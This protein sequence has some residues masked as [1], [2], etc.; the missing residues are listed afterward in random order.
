M[1]LPVAVQR[2]CY[3]GAYRIL[4]VTWF[5]TRPR[6]RG[7]KCLLTQDDRILLVRHTYGRRSWDL[8]GGGVKR[9]EPPIGA[10]RR[11]MREEL[12]IQAADW[13]AAG[14]LHGRQSFRRDTIHCFRAELTLPSLHLDRGELA[15]ARWF[16]RAAL[17]TD[18]GP[19]VLP[20]LT[21][22]LGVTPTRSSPAACS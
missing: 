4:Q 17:P 12:G 15:A 2:L 8:P 11:E 21:G 13:A 1:R 9:G 20:V 7:V 6:K 5:F 19:Y 16:H 22:A 18:L 3:R 14:E 10:A